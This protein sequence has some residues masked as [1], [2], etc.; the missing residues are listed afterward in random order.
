MPSKPRTA[1]KAAAQVQYKTWDTYV[2]E[3]QVE[4]FAL[5]IGDDETLTIECPSGAD[6]K[7]FALAQQ[8]GNSDLAMVS[9]FGEH[10]DRIEEL[11]AAAPFGALRDLTQDVGEHFGIINADGEPGESSASSTE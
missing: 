6:M 5:R 7:A 2:T 9:L 4:P 8:T 1:L 3:A 11:A 10:A